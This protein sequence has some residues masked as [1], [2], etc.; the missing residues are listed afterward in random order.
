MPISTLNQLRRLSKIKRKVP[1]IYHAAPEND[2]IVATITI[3][4]EHH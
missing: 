3:V 4:A 1:F 2:A